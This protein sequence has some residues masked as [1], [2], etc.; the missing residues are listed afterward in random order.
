M[1]G[2]NLDNT[3]R[4][5]S[6]GMPLG[7]SFY[8]TTSEGL[9][10]LEYCK[11]CYQ[12]GAFTEPDIHIDQMLKRSVDNMVG[13]NLATPE[14]AQGLAQSTIPHLKRWRIS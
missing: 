4:C 11:F 8:G 13:Q 6:C 2:V 7:Q 14:Q 3:A 1:T 12:N 9:P 5:Q 10:A